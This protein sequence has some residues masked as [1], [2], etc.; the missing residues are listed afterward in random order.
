[1]RGNGNDAYLSYKNTKQYAG[2]RSE[3]K[4]E[5]KKKKILETNLYSV[6]VPVLFHDLDQICDLHTC[7]S[8]F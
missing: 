8:V 6:L 7:L 4:K 3:R 2:T 1:M 5:R